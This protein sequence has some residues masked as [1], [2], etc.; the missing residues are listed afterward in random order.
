MIQKK[1]LHQG[2]ESEVP[3]KEVSNLYP[4]L[5]AK[6]LTIPLQPVSLQSCNKSSKT[7]EQN[8]VDKKLPTHYITLL[9][10]RNTGSQQRNRKTN[11]AKSRKTKLLTQK[12]KLLTHYA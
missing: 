1:E 10:T 4:N 12:R 9:G 11:Q 3:V 7:E 2:K 5:S 6:N 8:A